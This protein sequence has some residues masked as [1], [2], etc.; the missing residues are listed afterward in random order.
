MKISIEKKKWIA[1]YLFIAP[2]VVLFVT[3]RIYPLL[4]NFFLSFVKWD[5]FRNEGT[6]VG[7]KNYA[8]LVND[9]NFLLA[10]KNTVRY[11]VIFLPVQ[12]SIGLGL[13]LLV[14][15][16]FYGRTFCR[17]VFF[18]PY[19]VT[20]VATAA[21]WSWLYDPTSGLINAVL[22]RLHLPTSNWILSADTALYSVIIYSIWQSVGY[23]MIILLA[24]LQ[25]IPKQF[26]E[27]ARIDGANKF[28]SFVYVTLPL[29]FPTLLFVLV[30]MTIVSFGAFNQIFVMTEG[31]PRYATLVIV[32]YMYKTAF[33]YLNLSYAS[34]IAVV[35]FV[36]VLT[37]IIMQIK[38]GI[39]RS[40]SY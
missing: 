11:T 40:F 8:K 29:L 7:L 16:K 15:A 1:A 17:T 13:A 36:M 33:T 2:I 14:N 6:W 20:L 28:H 34:A 21:V 18:A 35:F 26:Y 12:I 39:R 27:A 5:P 4:S 37:I 30:M 32:L 24:G 9:K 23:S 10:V 31:G 3:F 38:L 25:A 19:I 22:Q